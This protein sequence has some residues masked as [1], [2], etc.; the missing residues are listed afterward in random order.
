[1]TVHYYANDQQM[2]RP[3]VGRT[4]AGCGNPIMGGQKAERFSVPDPMY[5]IPTRRIEVRHIECRPEGIPRVKRKP[6]RDRRGRFTSGPP[7]VGPQVGDR[8]HFHQ[9][10]ELPVDSLVRGTGNMRTYRMMEPNAQMAEHDHL[11]RE[12]PHGVIRGHFIVLRVGP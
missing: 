6:S 1:M 2:V 10:P 9:L 3:N 4:C 11:G 12:Y 8:I 5:L 7:Y